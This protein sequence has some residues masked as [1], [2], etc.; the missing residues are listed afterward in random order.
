MTDFIRGQRRVH[1]HV[2]KLHVHGVHG[3]KLPK[4]QLEIVYEFFT[5][6]QLGPKNLKSEVQNRV[7]PL[8]QQWSQVD[9]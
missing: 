8:G 7:R 5:R 3:V 6:D 2:V 4:S 9:H 1:V